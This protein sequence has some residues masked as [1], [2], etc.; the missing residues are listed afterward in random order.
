MIPFRLLIDP[1][2][3]GEDP[4]ARANGLA[5]KDINL[6]VANCLLDAAPMAWR[7]ESTRMGDEHRTLKERYRGDHYD[8][9]LALHC[10][11]SHNTD[12]G[13][14]STY[15]RAADLRAQLL[16]RA[17]EASAP[18]P[19]RPPRPDA[20]VAKADDWT[21]RAYNV[22][23][24]HPL[25]ALLVEMGFLSR[26]DQALYLSSTEGPRQLA[27]VLISVISDW[28]MQKGAGHGDA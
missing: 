27:R 22:L 26:T 7:C 11:V 24:R 8:L 9:V 16:G 5:E 25:P 21:R 17:I 19:L 28:S 10:D 14:L 12:V 23:Q 6:A 2:H 20:Q 1:G 4:G 15:A 18:Y 3:G 13:H